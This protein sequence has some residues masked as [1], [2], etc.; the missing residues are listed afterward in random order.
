[1][2]E[3]NQPAAETQ[4]VTLPAHTPVGWGYWIFCVLALA[5]AGALSYLAGAQA[6]LAGFTIGPAAMGLFGI[7]AGAV[8]AVALRRRIPPAGWW[9]LA[10]GVAGLAA[11]L[12]AIVSTSPAE[13]S[14]GLLVGWAYA[15]AAYG[16]LFGVLLQRFSRR[17]WLMLASLAG[18]AAAGFL[19]GVVGWALDVFQVA[20]SIPT[21]G[22]F[23]PTPSREW[24]VP[25]LA[26]IGAISGAAGGAVTGLLT[27][28][29]SRDPPPSRE[30]QGR[31]AEEPRS[32][33]FVGAFTGLAA[34]VLCT[35]LSRLVQTMLTEGS[36]DS[37]D[38][39]YYFL[40]TIYLSPVC[41]PTIA[42]V[43]V[44]LG[45]GGAYL[46][47]EL[48]RA[49]GRPHAKVLVWLGAIVGGVMGYLLGSL[50]AFAVGPPVE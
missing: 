17:R 44:P 27:F 42:V 9:F 46:G 16:A 25:G 36:L 22:A 14:L 12:V 5:A 37:L 3:Q 10:S 2:N 31:V 21:I 49:T 48:G 8:Q 11:A 30:G 38:L 4:D 41:L 47:L 35:W 19:G 45:I 43:S 39:T 23:F 24:S 13:S 29:I 18:W 28:R 6:P 40:S 34:A 1:M 33:K 20:P 15:W 7:L 50:L 26:L 32:V